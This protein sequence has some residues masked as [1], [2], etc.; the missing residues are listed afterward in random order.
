MRLEGQHSDPHALR[1]IVN[2][3]AVQDVMEDVAKAIQRDARSLAPRRTGNLR[4][5]IKAERHLDAETGFEGWAVGWDDEAFYGP[6][7]EE[8][9]EG[10]TPRPHLVPAAIKNGARGTR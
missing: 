6:F 9:G 10:R 3:P 1:E 4:R 8:G 5:H 2:S 7:V